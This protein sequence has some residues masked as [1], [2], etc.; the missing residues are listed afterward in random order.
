MPVF[1]FVCDDCNTMTETNI[2]GWK[3]GQAPNCH[4]CEKKQRRVISMPAGPRFKGWTTTSTGT[5]E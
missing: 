4:Q 3:E 1:E 2:P 5:N